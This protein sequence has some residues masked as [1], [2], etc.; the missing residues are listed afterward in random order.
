MKQRFGECLKRV[1]ELC[2]LQKIETQFNLQP[3]IEC[4]KQKNAWIA[5]YKRIYLLAPKN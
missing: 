1:L 2:L 5:R 3:R 4:N